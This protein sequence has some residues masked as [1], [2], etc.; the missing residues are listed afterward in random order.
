MENRNLNQILELFRESDAMYEMIDQLHAD[1][2]SK[3]SLGGAPGAIPGFVALSLTETFPFSIAILPDKEQAAYFFSNLESLDPKLPKGFLPDSFKSAGEFDELRRT[4]IQDRT[5]VVNRMTS[6]KGKFFLVTYPEAIFEKV[7]SPA[8]IEERQIKMV[9]GEEIDLDFLIEVLIEFGFDRVDFVAEPGEFSIRGGIIDLFSYGT[10]WPYRIEL[11]DD[12]IESIRLFNPADQLSIQ[13]VEGISIVPNVESKMDKNDTASLFDILPRDA[14]FWIWD[15][16][17]LVNRVQECFEK[18]KSRLQRVV[19][20]EEEEIVRDYLLRESWLLTR[21]FVDGLESFR[22]LRPELIQSTETTARI[23]FNGKPQP[24]FNKNF[25]LLIDDLRINDRK[26]ISTYLF[27]D[28]PRQ[29]NRIDNILRDLEAGVILHP[30]IASIDAGFIEEDLKIAC[31]TDHQIFRRFHK[32]KVKRGFSKD[33]AIQLRMLKELQAGDYVTHMDHGVGRYSGL[34]KINI[35]GHIQESVRLIYKNNDILYVSIHSLHKISKYVGRN[36]TAPKLSKLG[37]DTWTK[38]KAKTKKKIRDIAGD[39]IKLYAVRKNAE[40]FAFPEDG[41]LQN[42]LE[43]SF[44]YEDTPDQVTATQDVK[45][46]MQKSHPMDRLICGDVGFGKTE[47]AIRAVFKAVLGGKQAAVLVPTTILALQ[48]FNT[49]KERLEEFGV[50]IDYINRFRTAKQKRITL[51]NLADG[52]LDVVIGTH[53]LLNKK[54]K[55]KDLGLLVID[56]EQKFGVKSK[57]KLRT[58]KVN[59]DTLTLTATPIPRTLQ[60]S[61]LGAR[62]MSI[63]RTAPPNRQPIHTELR[64]FNAEMIRDA[65]YYEVDRGGQVF[66]VHNRVKTLPDVHQMLKKICPDL[67]FA[68]A[69]GQMESNQLEST[70]IKFIE[71]EG[72]VLLCTNIIETGLDI[73]NVNTMII[74]NAHHFGLSDLHQL[75]GRVGRSN[76]KAYCYLITPPMSALTADARKRLKTLEEF[77]DLGGGF[78]IAMRDMDIRG[79]GSLLGAEQ[80]GFISDIGYDAYQKILEEAIIDLKENEFKSLFEG[81]TKAKTKKPIYVRDVDIEFD[82]EMLIPDNYIANTQERL[83]IYKELD[84]LKSENE[85]VEFEKKLKDRFGPLPPEVF[86]LFDAF[87][88]RWICKELGIERLTLKDG[89]M[90]C[91]FP[92]KPTS[93]YYNSPVFGSIMQ[94]VAENGRKLNMYLKQSKESLILTREDTGGLDD[95][96]R[97][98]EKLKLATT[99]N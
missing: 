18:A 51:E 13:S 11:L 71:G 14:V 41:Y 5:E 86:N 10:D 70:L 26:G 42:E 94:F 78:Q 72:D 88:I 2:G 3:I 99:N 89:R 22:Q 31:Y 95:L 44:I 23:E 46:D 73:A 47:I 90:K 81:E 48:H 15:S 85:L 62:D 30:V 76:R 8:A 82:V 17:D 77:S 25:S 56:E 7:I 65:I 69:H 19:N 54:V 21:E 53:S 97:M 59:V 67:E 16:E 27:T 52:K 39:L 87:R 66:F 40:G 63:L 57:E 20:T 32:Y 24:N 9:K 61:L 50:N 12:E 36:S 83:N 35:N 28:N 75:R 43:A 58:I 79:A 6:F 34:E 64:I 93:P 37:T 96:K 80:S 1:S 49:F 60:F 84:E 92:S 38:L 4:Q 98:I 91:F 55:F 33:Q 68:M 29:F 45:N 74:N